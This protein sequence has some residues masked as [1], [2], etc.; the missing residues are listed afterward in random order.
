MSGGG[1]VQVVRQPAGRVLETALRFTCARAAVP[2]VDTD[3][4]RP[5][6]D[7]EATTA[8]AVRDAGVAKTHVIRQPRPRVS[9]DAN[10]ASTSQSIDQLQHT[11]IA[12]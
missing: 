6:A 4:R 9:P 11:N 1:A 10:N 7:V 8:V 3:V 5:V 12:P 2:T